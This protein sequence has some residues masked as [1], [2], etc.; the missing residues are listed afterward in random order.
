MNLSALTSQGFVVTLKLVR[1]ESTSD[2]KIE[3]AHIVEFTIYGLLGREEPYHVKLNRDI[4][5]FFG[6]NGSGKTSLLKILHSAMANDTTI[7]SR[8][9]FEKAEV[10]IY[11]ES[12]DQSYTTMFTQVRASEDTIATGG[13]RSYTRVRIRQN[14]NWDYAVMPPDPNP[15]RWNHRYL[16]TSRLYSYVPSPRQGDDQSEI[17]DMLDKYFAKSLQELWSSYSSEVLHAVRAAQADGLTNILR[18]V[19]SGE[20]RNSVDDDV[21]PEK[22]FK[23]VKSFLQRQGALEILG[24]YE[25]FTE[26][27]GKDN[28]LK[29]VISDINEVELRIENAMASRLQLQK[30][31]TRMFSGGK[32]VNFTDDEI[33]IEGG[34]GGIIE[35]DNLSSGEK[36]ALLLFVE[37]LMAETSS[38]MIDEPELSLHIDWQNHIV[39]DM[40]LL[41]PQGQIIIAT[42]SPEVMAHVKDDKIFRI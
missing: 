11:S 39:R 24:D 31:L 13:E 21:S 2:R 42:H 26:L 16:P 32:K 1:D 30:L 36:Q 15:S 20:N 37:V 33:L 12:Y 27:Y 6:A 9:V 35:I 8:V 10:V 28:R 5:I 23:K 40:Q 25:K 19:L 18:A 3:M 29:S 34:K 17:E 7:L 14:E 22:A 41:N 38:I 4:N